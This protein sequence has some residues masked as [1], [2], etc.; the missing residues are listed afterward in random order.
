MSRQRLT[1]AAKV[2]L[3]AMARAEWTAWGG[4]GVPPDRATMLHVHVRR[5]DGI[6]V[7]R[8]TFRRTVELLRR[9]GLVSKENPPWFTPAR[10]VGKLRNF[11][12]FPGPELTDEGRE[13]ADAIET[14]ARL[15]GTPRM[16]GFW[17]MV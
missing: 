5:G 10:E 15:R 14:A 3:V 2:A 6:E 9:L 11:G 7:T 17:W 12:H 13:L 8:Y 4:G 16:E 1:P